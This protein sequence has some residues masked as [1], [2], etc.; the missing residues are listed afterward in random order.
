MQELLSY[1]SMQTLSYN[2]R[3]L[4]PWPGTTPGFLALGPCSLSRWA[5]RKSPAPSLSLSSSSLI[6]CLSVSPALTL[7]GSR[8]LFLSELGY[9]RGMMHLHNSPDITYHHYSNTDSFSKHDSYLKENTSLEDFWGH[10]ISIEC[11]LP[12]YEI[13]GQY[14]QCSIKNHL[15]A[16]TEWAS[17]FE[18]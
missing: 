8:S 17:E 10:W 16:M 6:P 3:D 7:L 14:T 4:V 13:S 11:S 5:T 9:F 15:Q 1:H 12:L 18:E 2:T